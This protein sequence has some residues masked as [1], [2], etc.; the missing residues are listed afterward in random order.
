M[1]EKDALVRLE[2]QFGSL[3][4]FLVAL[5]ERAPGYLEGNTGLIEA[6]K[7]LEVPPALLGRAVVSDK[8]ATLLDQ[9][10]A[11]SEYSLIERRKTMQN[12]VEVATSAKKTVMTRAGDAKEIDRDAKEMIAADEHLRKLQQRPLD[13]P[14]ISVG[15]MLQINFGMP[16]PE[17]ESDV[18]DAQ[19]RPAHHQP[20]RAGDLPPRDA[21]RLYQKDSERPALPPGGREGGEFDFYSEEDAGSPPPDGAAGGPR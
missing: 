12:L 1:T 6:A 11:H 13:A 20:K 14:E 21:A 17:V 10:A 3:E 2:T 16:H 8:L 7:R 19:A 5:L 9:A 18:I 15:A 4:A